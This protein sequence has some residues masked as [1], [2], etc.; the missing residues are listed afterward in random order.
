M[1][2]PAGEPDAFGDQ[3]LR[4]IR[5]QLLAGDPRAAGVGPETYLFADGLIDSMRILDLVAFVE[6]TAGIRLRVA[7]V[8]MV[9]F[10]TPRAIAEFVAGH[11]SPP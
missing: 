4:F 5:R 7:D 8:T 6:S 11:R 3:L 10:R 1:T 9:H 2:D